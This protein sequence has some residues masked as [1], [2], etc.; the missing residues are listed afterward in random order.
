MTKEYDFMDFLIEDIGWPV[1]VDE[2]VEYKEDEDKTELV[3]NNWGNIDT[4]PTYTNVTENLAF[5]VNCNDFLLK[6]FDYSATK[7]SQTYYIA[8][9]KRDVP[10]ILPDWFTLGLENDS[11][12]PLGK[13]TCPISYQVFAESATPAYFAYD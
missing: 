4:G 11:E 1:K 2:F 9:T 10:V 12:F 3:F 13:K 7:T 6:N 5:S 8:T